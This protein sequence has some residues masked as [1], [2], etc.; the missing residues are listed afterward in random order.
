MQLSYQGYTD[1]FPAEADTAAHGKD[2]DGKN[3]RNDAT[4]LRKTHFRWSLCLGCIIY[5]SA[6]YSLPFPLQENNLSVKLLK[7]KI[8]IRE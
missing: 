8:I 4:A 5:L 7:E 3:N 1:L 6:V 2:Q